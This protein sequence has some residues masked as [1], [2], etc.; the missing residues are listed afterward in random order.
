MA[1]KDKFAEKQLI[2][3]GKRIRQLRIDQGYSSAEKFANKH[4]FGRVQYFRY[5][6]GKGNITFKTLS[7][8][9][10]AFGMSL[11]EFFSEGFGKK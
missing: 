10:K 3:L 1:T 6:S 2:L 5:E 4:D 7:V 9:V 11:E 8:L